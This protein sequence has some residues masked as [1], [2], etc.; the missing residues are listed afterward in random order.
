MRME[1][2]NVVELLPVAART[3]D[4]NGSAIDMLNYDGPVMIILT[5]AAGTGTTPTLDVTI[6]QSTASGTGFAAITGAAF[7]QVTDAADSTQMIQ[8][9]LEHRYIRA[10]STITGTT[11]SFTG[12][13]VALAHR[14]AGRNASQAV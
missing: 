5:S 6:E 8:I 14:H 1:Q 9:N 11:P 3:A 13:V 2:A 7:T 12:A 4:A 10:V